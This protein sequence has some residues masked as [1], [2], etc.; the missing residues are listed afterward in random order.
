MSAP[1]VAHLGTVSDRTR[2]RRGGAPRGTLVELVRLILVSVFAVGGWQIADRGFEGRTALLLGI[3][4]GSMVGYVVGGVIGR[5]TVRAVSEAEAEFQKVPAG[6]IL[7]GTIGLILGL[8]IAV[9]SS[10][11]LFRL[12]PEAAGPTIAFVAV[13]L[14]YAG[15]RIGRAKWA[16]FFSLFGLRLPGAGVRPG[17]INVVDTSALIDGRVLEVVTA[18]FL[19]GTF[20]VHRG[21]LDELQRIADSSDPKRRQRGRRGLDVLND[22]Q[23]TAEVVLVDEP[24]QGDVDGVLVRMAKDRGGVVITSDANLAKVATALDVPVRSMNELATAVR[25]PASAGEELTIHIS[26]EGR[27]AGQ[28]VGYLE[29]GTMV[30]VEQGRPHLGSDV[31]VTVTN[32]IQTASGRLLFARLDR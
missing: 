19:G 30:V 25:P 11:L 17:E 16:D 1:P 4:L 21:V 3:A 20:L 12:P 23:R 14:S 2:G 31:V 6:E 24:I 15:Y 22:L 9:L 13:S 26:R 10:F 32:V 18:G 28:G 27:E 5:L 29:D 7:A 8:S